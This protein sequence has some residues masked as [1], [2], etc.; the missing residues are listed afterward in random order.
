MHGARLSLGD[1]GGFHARLVNLIEECKHPIKL[2]L[3]ERVKFVVMTLRAAEGE[4]EHDLARGRD[5]VED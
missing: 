3:F 2:H 1:C 4:A 5:A